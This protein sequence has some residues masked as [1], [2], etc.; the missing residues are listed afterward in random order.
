MSTLS[1]LRCHILRLSPETL[2]NILTEA[3][4]SEWPDDIDGFKFGG[5]Y[6]TRWALPLVCRDFYPHAMR[7]LYSRLVL[8]ATKTINRREDQT[9][10]DAFYNPAAPL[11]PGRRIKRLHRTLAA[12]PELRSFCNEL[13]VDLENYRWHR[14]SILDRGCDIVRW[15]GNAE[16]LRIHNGFDCARIGIGMELLTWAAWPSLR[17]TRASTDLSSSMRMCSAS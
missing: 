3:A 17:A 1:T 4:E 11:Q 2:L 12:R 9:L 10:E 6:A 16:S 15:C 13:V 14:N 5:L 7:I 8:C